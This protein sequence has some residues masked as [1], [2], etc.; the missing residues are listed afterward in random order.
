MSKY[1]FLKH[2]CF[3]ALPVLLFACRDEVAYVGDSALASIGDKHLYKDEVALAYARQGHL[4]DSAEFVRNYI[5]R[6]VGET[7][8][9]EKAKEN[10]C[11]IGEMET[12]WFYKKK[13]LI[14]RKLHRM[15][16]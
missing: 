8:F 1:K 11:Y 5:E 3:F 15:K 10:E 4:T 16:R 14:P 2:I 12:L 7:L 13:S 6:W 9:Y